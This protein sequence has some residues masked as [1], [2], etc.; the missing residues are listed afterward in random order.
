MAPVIVTLA[1]AQAYIGL[2]ALASDGRMTRIIESAEAWVANL[3]SVSWT[4]GTKTDNV[5]TYSNVLYLRQGPASAITSV[6]DRDGDDALDSD[7]YRLSNDGMRLYRVAGSSGG[8][9]SWLQGSERWAVV[10][11]G[12]YDGTAAPVV[13]KEA[14][15][16]M[17]RRWWDLVGGKSSESSEGLTTNWH[18][19]NDSTVI[20]LLAPY[21]QRGVSGL[22]I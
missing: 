7:E 2:D 18:A 14:V 13:F 8:Y 12:G 4:N 10:Y 17:T 20:E 11:T 1:D 22:V 15:L 3:C 6:T 19:L 9:L 16:H 21:Q 5:S